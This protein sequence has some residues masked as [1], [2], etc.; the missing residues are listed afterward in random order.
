MKDFEMNTVEILV[1]FERLAYAAIC[2]L[3]N[4]EPLYIERFRVEMVE[5]INKEKQ[6]D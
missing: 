6:N 1:L 4:G 5:L 3:E 2:A